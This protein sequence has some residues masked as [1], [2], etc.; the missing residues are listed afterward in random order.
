MRDSAGSVAPLTLWLELTPRCN[1]RCAFCYNPWRAGPK[2]AHPAILTYDLYLSGVRRLVTRQTFSYVALSGGEPLLYPQL[3]SLVTF[4]AGAGQRTVLT[5][6]G[7]LLTRHLLTSLAA[8]GLT[9]LQVPLLAATPTVHDR[10]SGRASWDRAVR[11]L[12]LGLKARISTSATFIA[13]AANVDEL[14]RVVALLGAI[15]VR[16]L[17]VNEM[18]PHGSARLHAELGP[19]PTLLRDVL[20][21]SRLRGS[22]TGVQVRFIPARGV[23]AGRE[24]RRWDRL[25]MT[26]DGELKLCNQSTLTL[27]SLAE[28]PDDALDQVLADLAAGTASS[29]RDRVDCCRCFDRMYGPSHRPAA[30]AVTSLAGSM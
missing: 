25:A 29:Y 11:A 5:T 30:T 10:L 3:G 27:G 2:S 18:H 28:M 20:D 23:N 8:S 21:R 17:V 16:R 24:Q 7:R 15:G 1:L 9:G 4:L 6:N 13:T 19:D 26:S 12:A 22:E 14:P